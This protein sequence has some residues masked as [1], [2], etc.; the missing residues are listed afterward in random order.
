[1]RRMRLES[2]LQRARRALRQPPA[3]VAR[4]VAY[5]ASAQA[6]RYLAP[7]RARRFDLH[8][9]LEATGDGDLDRLWQRL[10]AR[11]YP[12]HTQRRRRARCTPCS[13]PATSIASARRLTTRSPIA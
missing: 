5:E 2:V 11:P 9:L 13:A 6:E 10:A 12:A 8:R 7:R 1:M 3:V 4:R